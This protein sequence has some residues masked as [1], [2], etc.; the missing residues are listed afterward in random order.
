MSAADFTA[1]PSE[2]VAD[3]GTHLQ[4]WPV[5]GMA[6]LAALI[7]SLP[8]LAD[9]MIRYDDYPAFFADAA[10]FWPKTL[11]EGR[12]VNYI[13]HLRE[14]VTPAWLNFA[15]YQIFWV[16][17]ASALAVLATGRGGLNWFAVTLAL[18]ILIAPP[19]VLIS[20]W[21]NTLLPG[22]ALVA[23]YA[24]IATR[25]QNWQLRALMP[26]FV[27]LTFMA[28][29]TYPLLL[30][31]VALVAT[32]RRSLLDLIGL[33]ALFTASF[34]LAVVVTYA[35]NWQVHGIFGVPLAEWRDASPAGDLAG[36]LANLPTLLGS[37]T[38]FLD[39]TSFGFFPA[40]I[41]HLT[42]LVGACM[43][44]LR[45]VPLEALYLAA[46]LVT[47]L[48]LVAVQV[49]KLG[50][51]VPPRAFI[52]AWVFYAVIVVRAAQEL[53]KSQ[54]FAGRMARNAVLL[55]VGSYLLQ[56][57]Q[58]YATYR[59][60]QAET[61][62]LAAT[63]KGPAIVTGAPMQTAA[64]REAGVQNDLAFA[65]RMQQLTGEQMTIC[66][67][68]PTACNEVESGEIAGDKVIRFPDAAAKN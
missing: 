43:I 10:A 63:I 35:V 28:Y 8:N 57:F 20:L 59:A 13:W 7:M 2:G 55:I 65:F 22:L 17:F 49:M 44:L 48:C 58:Q 23:A 52:F 54:G 29:T 32:K 61:R 25:L 33:L 3:R 16:C 9:P 12:W 1:L 26:V 15:L 42:M 18:M 4:I 68:A 66:S 56:V 67:E 53:S 39:K 11:H 24:L 19:A 27:L 6:A 47:G 64:A 21:F 62:S 36:Y 45:R 46:G 51:I 14:I 41:F 5:F 40:T 30:L 31:A 38:G 50:A 60:W 34:I 37:L